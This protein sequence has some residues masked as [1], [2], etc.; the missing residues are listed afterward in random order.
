MQ[1][2]CLGLNVIAR[3]TYKSNFKY[4]FF[5]ILK[6]D[7]LA[8][9]QIYLFF[10]YILTAIIPIKK[11]NIF[12]NPDILPLYNLFAS[13]ISSPVTIYSIA[14][15]AKLKHIAII[16]SDTEPIALPINAPTPVVIPERITRKIT[17]KEFIP[18]T[19]HWCSHR[20]SFWY[21]MY[22]NCYS[23]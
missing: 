12:P 5:T 19:F 4:R 6:T 3:K 8:V 10:C 9:S 18:P 20:Y 21:I 2:I 17:L 7:K 22:C 11:P 16:S 23:K 15:A 13:G 14:P 1:N